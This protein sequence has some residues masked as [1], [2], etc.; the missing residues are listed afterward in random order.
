ME[1]SDKWSTTGISFG[2]NYDCPFGRSDNMVLEIEIKGDI[3]NK[4]E[5]S[6]KEKRNCE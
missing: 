2:T 1:R 6:Y 5:E 4:L 3:E